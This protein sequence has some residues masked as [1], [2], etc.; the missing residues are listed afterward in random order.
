MI[1]INELKKFIYT[2][3]LFAFCLLTLTIVSAIQVDKIYFDNTTTIGTI[4]EQ[5]SSKIKL[6]QN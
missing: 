5:T 6:A 3:L 2:S 1:L 4:E